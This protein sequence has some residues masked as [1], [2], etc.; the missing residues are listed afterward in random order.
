MTLACNIVRFLAGSLVELSSWIH[1]RVV[2]MRLNLHSCM[3]F[4]RSYYEYTCNLGKRMG[5]LGGGDNRIR[6]GRETVKIG[7][8]GWDKMGNNGNGGR[9]QGLDKK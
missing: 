3:Q 6:M 5:K 1:L 4:C 7:G 2:L 9:G 8:K